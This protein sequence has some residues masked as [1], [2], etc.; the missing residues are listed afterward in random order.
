MS[1]PDEVLDRVRGV[2]DTC[3]L[4]LQGHLAPTPGVLTP[5]ILLLNWGNFWGAMLDYKADPFE[6]DP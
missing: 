1:P 6:P 4:I 3:D 5:M 2:R